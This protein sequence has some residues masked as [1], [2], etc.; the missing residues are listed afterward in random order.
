MAATR[1]T[2]PFVIPALDRVS[3][4]AEIQ[5]GT[6]VK[7]DDGG[8]AVY[9]QAGSEVAQYNAVLLQPAY[10]VINLT[11]T[12]VAEGTGPREVAWAQTSIA[13]GSYGWVQ[14]SGRP[15]GKAAANA[16]DNVILFTTATAGVVDDATVSAALLAGV[17]SQTSISNATA[18][19][20]V[21]PNGA[22]VHPFVNPA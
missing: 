4:E 18:V 16:A 8:E 15:V 9:V 12:A 20:L 11:T 14:K 22:H 6:T 3:T 1:H 5:V 21:V 19:T 13:S 10:S 2:T 7:T 17:V